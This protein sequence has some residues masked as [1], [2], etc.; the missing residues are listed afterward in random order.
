MF[1]RRSIIVGG[2]TLVAGCATPVRPGTA[3]TAPSRF[4]G[5]DGLHF[6]RDGKPYRYAGANV[7]YGAWLGADTAYGNRARLGR[8]LDRLQALGVRNLRII[9]SAEESPLKNSITPGFRGKGSSYNED[10]LKG[11]DWTLAEM[12]KRDM[13]AIVYLANF[14]EWSG[15]MMTYLSWVNGGNFINMND[16]AHPW[17]EFPDRNAAFYTSRPAQT[18]LRDY[19]RAVVQRTNS[20]TGIR[21][22]DDPTIMAWQLA[23]EPRP[24]GSDAV[25]VPNLPNFYRWIDETARYIKA[26]DGHHLVTTGSEGLKGS[27]ERE[28][29][30][31]DAH[32]SPAIDYMTTHIWPNNWSWMDAGNLATTYDAGSAK[33]ADYIAAHV[34]LARQ[35]GKPLVIEEFGYPRDGAT[36]YDPKIATTFKDR[37]YRQIYAAVEADTAAGGPLAGSNFWAWNGEARTPH[38]DYR[39]VRGD[40][41]YMGDPPHEP[42]GWYGVF[43]SDA[44]TMAV[45]KAHAAALAG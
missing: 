18:L 13:T 11:L 45:I 29:V 30:V 36:A 27:I 35:L 37:F 6:V 34:R 38:A 44:S 10:L 24:G 7:W 40:L 31:L 4:V 17:P 3:G 1:D 42:Q 33:V 19:I 8:E 20:V 25:A 43:D 26:L 21:Y 39:F 32:R 22:A 12:A 41:G 15:G 5:V 14:W 2:A 16:P 9:G 28:D 23:N